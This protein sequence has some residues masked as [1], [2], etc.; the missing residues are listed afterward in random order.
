MS[1]I[2]RWNPVREMVAMQ[3]A[4]DRLFDEAWRGASANNPEG[5]NSFNLPLDLHESDDA[6]TIVTEI[7]GVSVENINIRLDDNTLLIDAEIPEQTIEKEG[8]RTLVKERRYGKFSRQIRL[9]YE[10]NADA[11]EASFENGVLH[12]HLPKVPAVQPKQIAVK[13]I[14][15]SQN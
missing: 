10:V 11:V 6:Y 2:V 13:A 7:P 1:R 14:K 9:P 3:S 12:L 5:I 4:L 8:T 15:P